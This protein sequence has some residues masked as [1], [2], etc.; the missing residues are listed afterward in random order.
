MKH[1]L[2]TSILLASAASG[3]IRCNVSVIA[4][5]SVLNGIPGPGSKEHAQDSK[6]FNQTISDYFSAKSHATNERDNLSG[7]AK[8]DASWN[9]D[10]NSN[11]LQI[12]GN[13]FSQTANTSNTA[14]YLRAHSTLYCEFEIT[15]TS[16]VQVSFLLGDSIFFNS[17]G[18]LY[19][20]RVVGMYSQI[21]W[22][23]NGSK[24]GSVTLIPG[25]YRLSAT[26]SS[27][28]NFDDFGGA[29]QTSTYSFQMVVYP[30]TDHHNWVRLNLR[31]TR[32]AQTT[33]RGSGYYRRGSSVP[34]RSEVVDGQETLV[35]FS[36]WKTI[37]PAEI[38]NPAVESTSVILHDNSNVLAYYWA[39]E[40]MMNGPNPIMI[41]DPDDPATTINRDGD[42]DRDGWTN[43]EE[44]LHGTHPREFGSKKMAEFGSDD[45]NL[46]IW[47]EG[48]TSKG[49]YYLMRSA[50]LENFSPSNVLFATGPNLRVAATIPKID[51][52]AFYC[53]GYLPPWAPLP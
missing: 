28:Q 45:E 33:L 4:T 32:P 13:A 16:E 40:Q 52:S 24:S 42:L 3:E 37:N 19:L 20:D 50:T 12:E 6:T 29:P 11:T 35:H 44:I 53:I 43:G 26:A 14:S 31:T 49:T 21:I 22:D 36:G 5:G 7:F 46:Y 47:M 8:M 41:P 18:K 38:E 48:A 17:G 23:T 10:S 27:E 9:C 51:R 1:Q 39:T 25:S 15:E 30:A 2:L 34:I